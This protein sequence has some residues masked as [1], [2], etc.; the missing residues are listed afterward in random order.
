MKN[1]ELENIK[2]TR[3]FGKDI[4]NLSEALKQT[5]DKPLLYVSR[6]GNKYVVPQELFEKQCNVLEIIKQKPFE[7]GICINYININIEYPKMQDYEHYCMAIKEDKRVDKNEFE[8]L[9][10]VFGNDK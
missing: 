3:A 1:K 4:I 6:Y 9:K 8:I 7:S 10:G 5:I 2:N